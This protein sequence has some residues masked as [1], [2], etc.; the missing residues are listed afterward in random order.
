MLLAE[1]FSISNIAFGMGGG[2]LQKNNRDT[3]KFAMKACAR[4]ADGVWHDI[5][6]DPTI[7]DP[8][9]WKPLRSSFKKSM[10]GR[11]ELMRKG[12]DFKTVR[13]E[14]VA[15]LEAQGYEALLETVYDN[16]V[17]VRDMTF[18]EVRENA[19]IPAERIAIDRTAVETV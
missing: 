2:L 16:G 17:L 1:N 14:E 8:K 11:L 3:L 6:K 18:D 13:I 5:S 10:A 7:Y 15:E 4:H 12:D 9:T 19:K